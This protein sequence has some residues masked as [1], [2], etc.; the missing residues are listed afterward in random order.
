MRGR[1]PQVRQ[2]GCRDHPLES[3][4]RPS[5]DVRRQMPDGQAPKDL[6]R[7]VVGESIHIGYDNALR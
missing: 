2:P 1:Q 3:H 4:T 6:F 5:V 7:I